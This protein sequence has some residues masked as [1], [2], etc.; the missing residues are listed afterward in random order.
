MRA[1]ND[2]LYSLPSSER[3]WTRI[4]ARRAEKSPNQTW[5]VSIDDGDELTYSEAYRW[6]QRLAAGLWERGLR[7]G[8]SVVLQLPGSLEHVLL[9][10]AV[11]ACGATAVPIHPHWDGKLLEDALRVAEPELIIRSD[12]R[13]QHTSAPVDEGRARTKTLTLSRSGSLDSRL[14][15]LAMNDDRHSVIPV[16]VKPQDEMTVVFTSG[17]TG[18]AKGVSISHHFWYVTALDYI[19]LVRLTSKDRI[20]LY[21]PFSHGGPHIMGHLPALLSGAQ[22][23]ITAAFSV[24]NFW[25]QVHEYGVTTF[26]VFGNVPYLLY[27]APVGAGDREHACRVAVC[28]PAPH[29][30]KEEFENRFGV[31]LLESYAMTESGLVIHDDQGHRRMGSCGRSSSHY[32]VQLVD[33]FGAPVEVG[34]PGEI[35][36]RPLRPGSMFSGYKNDPVSTLEAFRG[37]WFHTGDRARQDAEGYFYFVDRVTDSIRRSGENISSYQVE[38]YVLNQPQVLECAVVGVPSD[39]QEEEVLVLARLHPGVDYAERELIA[40]LRRVMPK[41]MWPRYVAFVEDFDRTENGKLRKVSYRRPI[42]DLGHLRLF[43]SAQIDDS[44]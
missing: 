42:E 6:V 13:D 15:V 1:E 12:D 38:S 17:T 2:D 26:N 34:Q 7:Q 30:I 5:L 43:D 8:N 40:D 22:V 44:I 10:H 33:E 3:T 41:Y 39:I 27:G 24:T 29:K 9:M 4:L 35:V 20:F 11:W 21:L 28:F 18:P 36:T 19:G 16:D 14:D 23:V 31:T 25:R 32:Q 37:L